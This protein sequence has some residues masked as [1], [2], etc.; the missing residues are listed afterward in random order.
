[1]RRPNILH[2]KTIPLL[3]RDRDWVEPLLLIP[4]HIIT[5]HTSICQMST[6]GTAH[7]IIR[8]WIHLAM[9]DVHQWAGRD[10]PSI[11]I[12]PP[13][14][15]NGYSMN[16]N[17]QRASI[18][19]RTS[20]I[21]NETSKIATKRD[22]AR[23]TPIPNGYFQ[24]FAASTGQAGWSRV[25]GRL[26]VS[27]LFDYWWLWI[28]PVRLSGIL[29]FLG[30]SS[31]SFFFAA[32][33]RWRMERKGN[34]LNKAIRCMHTHIHGLLV[35]GNQFTRWRYSLIIHNIPQMTNFTWD[36]MTTNY[37]VYQ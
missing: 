28:L 20:N 29:F 33:C 10:S 15:R 11:L 3:S 17:P 35:A 30:F 37:L 5:I 6:S 25:K 34:E 13:Q 36:D 1:M 32:W 4:I 26:C 9:T 12:H 19:P 24:V 23:H 14:E 22:H 21:H 27:V 7:S 2:P 8:R 31:I 18:H 16:I